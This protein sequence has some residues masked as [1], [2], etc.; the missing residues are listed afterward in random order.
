MYK[1]VKSKNICYL[2]YRNQI[3]A[4]CITNEPL[5]S[6]WCLSAISAVV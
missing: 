6:D 2:Q 4:M 5:M 1:I 3:E